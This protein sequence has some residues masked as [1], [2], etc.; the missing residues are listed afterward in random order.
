MWYSQLLP[1]P[2]Y[3]LNKI[4]LQL[5]YFLLLHAKMSYVKKA[6]LEFAFAVGFVQPLSQHL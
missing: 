6:Y 1:I 3:V 4:Q 2:Q 5:Y